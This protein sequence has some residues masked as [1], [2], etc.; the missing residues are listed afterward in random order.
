MDESKPFGRKTNL[1]SDATSTAKL[2]E[3][4]ESE[5]TLA[6]HETV[7]DTDACAADAPLIAVTK[8]ISTW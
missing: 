5:G 6:V 4:R 2:A 7:H 3:R 1:A 8:T